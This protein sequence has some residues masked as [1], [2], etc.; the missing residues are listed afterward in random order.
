MSEQGLQIALALLLLQNTLPIILIKLSTL[1]CYINMTVQWLGCF[2]KVGQGSCSI[3]TWRMKTHDMSSVGSSN[4]CVHT[5]NYCLHQV[6][7]GPFTYLGRYM[8]AVYCLHDSSEG[9]KKEHK[10]SNIIHVNQS[11]CI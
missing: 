1:T 7:I 10:A 8:T 6:Q 11:V 3:Y 9:C 4:K 5:I 2:S